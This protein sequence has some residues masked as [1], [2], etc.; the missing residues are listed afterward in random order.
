VLRLG[1][2]V[3]ASVVTVAIAGCGVV[4]TTGPAATPADFL[5]ISASIVRR[6]VTI[7]HPV[8]GDA[9][10][11]DTTLS[12]TAISFRASGLDQ[13]TAVPLHL[14]IFGSRDSYDR[15]RPAV[16]DCAHSYVANAGATEVVEAPPFVVVGEGPWGP[17]FSAAIRAALLEAA[18]TGG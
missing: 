18:G 1:R 7:E 16:A 15:L 10:C 6:G 8:S 5:G 3:L 17:Q 2:A 13:S 11:G 9:G 14:Y 12:K 4:S